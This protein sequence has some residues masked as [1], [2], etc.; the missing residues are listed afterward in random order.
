MSDFR[1]HPYISSQETVKTL[2]TALTA[3]W[4]QENELP[5]LQERIG[6]GILVQVS[7]REQT[8]GLEFIDGIEND[9]RRHQNNQLYTGLIRYLEQ[10]WQRTRIDRQMSIYYFISNIYLYSLISS[11]ETIQETL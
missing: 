6:I 5:Y 7:Q 2:P 10:A 4:A 8:A 1:L 9:K 3:S 11:K